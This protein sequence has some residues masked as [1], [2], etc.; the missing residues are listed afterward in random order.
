M[1]ARLLDAVL[2]HPLVTFFVLA[3][4]FSWGTFALLGGP[5]VFPFGPFLAALFTA[6][7]TRGKAGLKEW[8]GRCLR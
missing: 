5:F 6:S 8:L 1:V 4:S 7:V 2:L 3:Y